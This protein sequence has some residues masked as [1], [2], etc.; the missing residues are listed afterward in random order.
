MLAIL[1]AL[2]IG[3]GPEDKRPKPAT[4]TSTAKAQPATPVGSVDTGLPDGMTKE[5]LQKTMMALQGEVEVPAPAEPSQ[6]PPFVPVGSPIMYGGSG[7][8][9]RAYALISDPKTARTNYYE[10]HFNEDGTFTRFNYDDHNAEVTE[11]GVYRVDQRGNNYS[12]TIS[13]SRRVGGANPGTLVPNQQTFELL[14]GSDGWSIWDPPVSLEKGL[15]WNFHPAPGTSES[16][17]RDAG[18]QNGT[19]TGSSGQVDQ[20]LAMVDQRVQAALKQ[21]YGDDRPFN[22]DYWGGDDFRVHV[23]DDAGL[24]AATKWLKD[25][26]FYKG[27]GKVFIA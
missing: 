7:Y 19:S 27:T 26:G 21:Q 16:Y 17:V 6:K 22:I 9:G 13:S 23:S 14:Q 1:A 24:A 2:L 8:W 18:S 20:R 15:R 4:D 5:D 10:Y 25:H 3:F 12:L 11:Y